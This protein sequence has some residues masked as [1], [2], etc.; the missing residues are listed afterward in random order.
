V[1]KILPLPRRQQCGNQHFRMKGEIKAI[2]PFCL[3]GHGPRLWLLREDE[4]IEVTEIGLLPR[5]VHRILSVHA[6]GPRSGVG[7]CDGQVF[8]ISVSSFWG[9]SLS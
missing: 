1:D 5:V 9:T 2:S 4:A 6:M 7:I 3:W 8:H